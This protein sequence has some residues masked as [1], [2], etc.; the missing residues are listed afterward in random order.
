M[1]Q[2]QLLKD[3]VGFTKKVL[4]NQKYIDADGNEKE[5]EVKA[6]FLKQKEMRD[7]TYDHYVLIRV[8]DGESDHEESTVKVRF[9]ICVADRDTIEGWI[10]VLNILEDIRQAILSRTIICKRYTYNDPVKWV[11][12]EDEAYP[13]YFA[14]LDVQFVIHNVGRTDLDF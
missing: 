8:L 2:V 1:T 9:I 7:N 14:T 13:A 6:G 10:T 12:E 5:I 11:V 3:L 4:Q